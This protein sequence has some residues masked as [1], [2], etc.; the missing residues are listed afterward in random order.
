MSQ[1]YAGLEPF[2]GSMGLCGA[3]GGGKHPRYFS[4]D[5]AKRLLASSSRHGYPRGLISFHIYM[6]IY[7]YIC[8][9]MYMCI[10]YMYVHIHVK[11]VCYEKVTLT[12]KVSR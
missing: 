7:I 2:F 11:G 5:Y 10:I 3:A 6:Y 8:I 1:S 9:Y 12:G 4:V